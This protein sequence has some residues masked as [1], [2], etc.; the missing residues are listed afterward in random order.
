[1]KT[2]IRER[3]R[4]SDNFGNWHVVKIGLGPDRFIDVGTRTAEKT[5]ALATKIRLLLES[6]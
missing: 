1:M 5:E 3:F 6:V 2:T 4:N